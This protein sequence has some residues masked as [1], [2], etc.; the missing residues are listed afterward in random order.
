MR[1]SYSGLGNK[2]SLLSVFAVFVAPLIPTAAQA[3]TQI[4][5]GRSHSCA[6]T[7]SG[8]MGHSEHPDPL[9]LILM[10]LAIACLSRRHK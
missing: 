8:A 7:D 3:A 1:D 6:V 9:L 2:A 4:S 10:V 5:V